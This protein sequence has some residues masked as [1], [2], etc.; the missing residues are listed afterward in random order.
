MATDPPTPTS[1]LPGRTVESQAA[2][3][4]PGG[5]ETGI[6]RESPKLLDAGTFRDDGYLQEANRGFFHPLGLALGMS[7]AGQL[8]MPALLEV[9]DY[10]EDPEG[11][12]FVD[13]DLAPK[14][15]R[16]AEISAARRPAREKA[17]GYW[18]QP[19]GLWS[20]PQEPAEKSYG[21][22]VLAPAHAAIKAANGKLAAAELVVQVPIAGGEADHEG[23]RH[24]YVL[25]ETD[26]QLILLAIAELALS[27]PGFDDALV[28]ISSLLLGQAT[29][30]EFKRLNSDRVK[31]SHGPFGFA[32]GGPIQHFPDELDYV[33]AKIRERNEG[34]HPQSFLGLFLLACLRA[35][36]QNYS[37]LRPT[38]QEFVKKY[39]ARGDLLESEL[40]DSP[41]GGA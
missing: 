6:L 16:L 5:H 38:L 34:D 7:A 35:D 18:Q 41:A 33:N 29:F 14:A 3:G 24:R 17:L 22:S 32:P 13:G 8:D 10:R 39:P 19:A 26:R 4:P 25:A 11:I 1:P 20:F 40:R 36:G 37:M 21:T 9:W 28:R 23:A 27:R 15:A 30:E 12:R 2:P 31:A